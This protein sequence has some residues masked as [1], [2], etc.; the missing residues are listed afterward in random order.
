MKDWHYKRDTV[1]N[2]QRFLGHWE[3]MWWALT[4]VGKFAG[5]VVAISLG[6]AVYEYFTSD[7]RYFAFFVSVA[8]LALWVVVSGAFSLYLALSGGVMSRD[9]RTRLGRSST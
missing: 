7:D 5:V 1:G 8:M 9:E 2:P 6:R 3:A 4:R